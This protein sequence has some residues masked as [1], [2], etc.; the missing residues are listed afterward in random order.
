VIPKDHNTGKWRLITD[1][2]FP[3]GQSVSYGIDPCLC[4]LKYTSVDTVAD[5]INKLSKG[6]LMAMVDVEAAYRLAL[7]HPQDRLLQAVP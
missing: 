6:T 4:S 2:S 1:L 5:L 7:V 3:E